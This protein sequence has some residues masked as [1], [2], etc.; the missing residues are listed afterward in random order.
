MFIIKHRKIFFAISAALVLASLFSI[1]LF[2]F[3]L[4]LDFTGG[5]L[6][7]VRYPDGRPGKVDIETRLDNLALG[8]YSLRPSGEESFVLRTRDLTPDEQAVILDVL[9]FNGEREVVL[10]RFASV[11]PSVGTELSQK[12]LVAISIV[13]AVI[14]LFV[15]FVFRKVSEPISSWK[16]GIIAIVALVHDVIIPVGFFA[17]LGA[18][19]GAEVDVLFVMALLAILGYSVNDTIVVFDRVRENLRHNRELGVHEDF[20]LTVGKSVNQT[21][22]R[23]INTSL[24]TAIALLSLFFIGAPVTQNFALVLLAGVV[25]GTYSSIALA[26]PLLVSVERFRKEKT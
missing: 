12:A 20:E 18:V 24:S 3:P 6:S 2:G 8:G 15:A 17:V 7:E 14:I 1:A 13:I 23:S 9:S 4:G 16:Y 5:A 21:F 11:G 25:A 26:T 22:T 19:F 10:E